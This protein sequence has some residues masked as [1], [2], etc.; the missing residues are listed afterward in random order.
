MLCSLG[1]YFVLRTTAEKVLEKV[2]R[3]VVDV[4]CSTQTCL[5]CTQLV[6]SGLV[7]STSMYMPMRMPGIPYQSVI[8]AWFPVHQIPGTRYD[9]FHS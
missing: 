3:V 8:R 1:E 9:V 5:G 6:A 4:R 2:L 7:S